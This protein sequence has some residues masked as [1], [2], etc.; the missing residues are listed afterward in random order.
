MPVH[1][2]IHE[3]HV[4]AAESSAG[5]PYGRRLW[6]ALL[7]VVLVAACLD[8]YGIRS[9]PMADD[10]VPSLVE[11][12]LFEV[13]GNAFSVPAAQLERL[14]KALPV[15]YAFQRTALRLFPSNEFGFRLPSLICALIFSGLAFVVA[16]RWRGIWYGVAIAIIVNLSQ[17]FVYLAQIDRFYSMPLLL[18]ALTLIVMCTP[19]PGTWMALATAALAALTVLSHNVTIAVFVLAFIA[20]ACAYLVGR[21]PAYL[22]ARSGLAASVSVLLYFSFIRPL[23]N[24]WHSTGNPTPVLVSFAAH[25]GIPS[26]GL[27]ML[28][29]WLAV[30]ESGRGVTMVWWGLM[31]AGSLCFL[32]LTGMTWNPRYFLF[33]FPAMW[34]LAAYAMERVARR[35]EYGS[36]AAAWYGLV[37]VLLMP[38]LLSHFRDG[39]R[40]DYRQAAAVLAASAQ[41]QTILSDDA[42]TISYYLPA[43]LRRHLFVRTKVTTF[44]TDEFSLVTRS[45]AW[46]ALPQI[47]GR[48]LQLMSEI[49]AR[50][51]DQF[52]HILRVYRIA[53]VAATLD[54]GS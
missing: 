8:S 2:A 29:I 51:Y 46:T 33:F 31:L 12:R 1:Q 10:E 9:W 45:N 53:P 27:A 21:A 37:V 34:V 16:A 24:G 49:Y 15:W 38:S 22:L 14:P 28:G 19:R 20:A 11:M 5:E 42:E 52:S 17:P 30:E 36:G 48:H 26:L 6:L 25:A 4:A 47:P 50:R 35:F 40:H 54:S 43:N 7:V 32:Y 18:L 3:P 23:V 39:S 41:D 13:P 44:P